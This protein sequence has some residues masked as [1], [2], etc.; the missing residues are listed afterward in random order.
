MIAHRIEVVTV[1]H[2][3]IE[4]A[5]ALFLQEAMALAY[6]RVSGGMAWRKSRASSF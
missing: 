3:M 2:K 4:S 6:R 5:H 1:Q